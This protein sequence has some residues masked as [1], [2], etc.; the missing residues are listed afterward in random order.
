MATATPIAKGGGGAGTMDGSSAANAGA[1]ALQ[2]KRRYPNSA[3]GIYWIKPPTGSAVQVYCDMVLD[4]G[5]WMLVA[6]TVPG[7][8]VATAGTWGWKGPAIGSLSTFSSPYQLGIY[9]LWQ[10]GLNFS[11]FCYGNQKTNNDYSWGPYV[12]MVSFGS[13]GLSDFF[14]NDTYFSIG[15]DAVLQQDTTVYGGGSIFPGMQQLYGYATTG[16]ADDCYYLRDVPGPS[17]GGY[18]INP[19]GLLTTYCNVSSPSWY[20]GAFCNGHTL[21]GN[22]YVQ[23]GSNLFSNMGGTDQVMLMVR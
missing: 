23:G 16:T 4:G 20:S 2:I 10:Q 18:G 9:A 17:V 13:A 21:S 7:G 1:S 15:T 12:Y 8:T 22:N 11:Q 19:N 3:S 6:H 5:G 14:S